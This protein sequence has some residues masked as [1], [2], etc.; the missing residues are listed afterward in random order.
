MRNHRYVTAGS[1]TDADGT[2]L[3]IREYRIAAEQE[4]RW[5]VIRATEAVPGRKTD[6]EKRARTD[7]MPFK[8]EM[9]IAIAVMNRAVYSGNRE[10]VE[11]AAEELFD[12]ALAFTK[13]VGQVTQ[14]GRARIAAIDTGRA[15]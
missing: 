14:A 11:R 7:R 15:A 4:L 13:F 10:I 3:T 9:E 6:R 8:T 2:P 5:R 1:D 12:M